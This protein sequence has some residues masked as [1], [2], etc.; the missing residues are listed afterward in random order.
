MFRGKSLPFFRNFVQ[1]LV[2]TFW[3]LPLKIVF[4]F[5]FGFLFLN[6]L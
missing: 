4:F 2:L 1:A 3:A 5:T 6:V